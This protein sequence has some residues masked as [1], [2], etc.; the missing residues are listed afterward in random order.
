VAIAATAAGLAPGDVPADAGGGSVYRAADD[1][2]VAEAVE[3]GWAA[4]GC[5]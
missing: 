2:G 1:A 3:M 4:T 5:M